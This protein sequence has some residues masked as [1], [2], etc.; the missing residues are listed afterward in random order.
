MLLSIL[1][2]VDTNGDGHID[3]PGKITLHVIGLSIGFGPVVYQPIFS[4]IPDICRPYR[5]WAMGALPED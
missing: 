3:Y 4:R 1:R 2:A 5:A